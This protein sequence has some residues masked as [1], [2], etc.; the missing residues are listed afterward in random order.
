MT[1]R[2][3]RAAS[4]G[5]AEAVAAVRSRGPHVWEGPVSEKGLTAA[6]RKA[7]R[8]A[9]QRGKRKATEEPEEGG[10]VEEASNLTFAVLLRVCRGF[11]RTSAE[12]LLLSR[13]RRVATTR[14]FAYGVTSFR[15]TAGHKKT[16]TRQTYGVTLL[17]ARPLYPFCDIVPTVKRC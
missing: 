4:A 8:Q 10:E 15:A 11:V 12:S 7:Q 16:G 2:P 6:Q 5:V 13:S 9:F 3:K 14:L 1:Q 17:I